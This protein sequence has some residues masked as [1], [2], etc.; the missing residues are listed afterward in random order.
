[1]LPIFRAHKVSLKEEM[2]QRIIF[3][4][5]N[6]KFSRAD[7]EEEFGVDPV[8][9]YEE[10]FSSLEAEGF[11]KIS[12]EY[13]ETTYEGTLFADDIVREFFLEDHKTTMLAHVKRA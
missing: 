10:K 6:L 1:M 5:K 7:F 9:L 4:I 3:G 12:P 13:V 11:I 2:I 8:K